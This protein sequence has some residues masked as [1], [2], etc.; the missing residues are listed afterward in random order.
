MQPIGRKARI[1]TSG[2]PTKLASRSKAGD[3]LYCQ[4]GGTLLLVT[5]F[6]VALFGFAALSVDVGNVLVHRKKISEAADAA[7]LAAVVD[8]AE[9][10]T[11]AKVQIVARQYARANDLKDS[12]IVSVDPG[13]WVTIS[14]A[15]TFSA[16]RAL[17][18]LLPNEVAAVRVQAR[19]NVPM[20]FGRVVGLPA[21]NPQVE[22]VAIAGRT[23]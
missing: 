17:P 18:S 9:N 4:A 16:V 20:Y 13:I 1:N 21:M 19:R 7:A 11:S 15:G 23:P 22:A 6:I 5:V 12:E 2:Q 10:G 8:W 3:S 14:G